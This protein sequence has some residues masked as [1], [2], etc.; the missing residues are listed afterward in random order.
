M[1]QEHKLHFLNQIQNSGYRSGTQA[2]AENNCI[3][4]NLSNVFTVRIDQNLDWKDNV[5]EIAFK[6]IRGNAILTKL[7]CYVSKKTL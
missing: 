3:Y 1:L 7:R 4:L 2:F 6:L 5:Y